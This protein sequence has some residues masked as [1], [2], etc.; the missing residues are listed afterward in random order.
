M[1]GSR[2]AVDL[3]W[4]PYERQIG[5]T[6]KKITPRLLFAIGIS[7][8]FEFTIGIKESKFIL[9]LNRDPNAPIFKIA[10]A[11]IVGDFREILPRL[12][13]VLR[14]VKR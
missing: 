13:E 4:I 9:A 12:N 14:T 8:A 11:G 2:V 5:L 1:A 10:D 3:G 6:G 7:G